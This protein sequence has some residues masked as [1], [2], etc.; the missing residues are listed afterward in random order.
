MVSRAADRLL[1]V[2]S[3]LEGERGR[4]LNTSGSFK[5][6]RRVGCHRQSVFRRSVTNG[7]NTTSLHF[8]GQASNL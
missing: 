3:I 1:I 2:V 4:I 7:P 8:I 6:T 5:V